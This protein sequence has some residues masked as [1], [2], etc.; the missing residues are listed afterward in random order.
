M[1]WGDVMN[2]ISS[3]EMPP[4]DQPQPAATQATE[5]VNWLAA[6]IKEGEAA[7]L[8]KRERVTFQKL[9]RE[10][11]AH[12]VYDMLGIH[13]D[14]ADPSALTE[15]PSWNGFERIGSVLSFSPAH[16]EKH[17]AAAEAVVAEA[18]PLQR[19][20]KKL[21]HWKP[22]DMRPLRYRDSDQ[23]R[24]D[25]IRLDVWPG[26]T[27]KGQ[28]THT[29]PLVV[30]VSG[31]YL[32][33]VKLSGMQ[34]RGGRAPHVEIYSVDLNRMLLEQDVVTAEDQPITVERRVHLTAGTHYVRMTNDAPGPSNLPRA[35]RGHLRPFYTIQ[36][37]RYPWQTKITDDQGQPILPFLIVDW[38]EFEGPLTDS[39][40]SAA[41]QQ[42]T[43]AP[44]DG[45]ERAREVITRFAQRLPPSGGAGGGRWIG[46]HHGP[47]AGQ[48]R[49]TRRGAQEHL[50]GR[51]VLERFSV[52]R[53]RIS[54]REGRTHHRLG[55]RDAI[56]LLLVEFAAGCP[57]ARSG[58]QRHAAEPAVLKAQVERML[59]DPKILHF[60]EAFARQW[61]Q[62]RLVGM[63]P[64]D[65]KLYPDYDDYLQT[66]M[67][68]ESIEYFREVLQ[69]DLTLREFLDS[70]WTMLNSRLAAHYGIPDV[71][72]DRFERVTLR[73]DDH[74]GGLLTQASIWSL[75][76]DGT[77]HRPVH[78]G[79]WI[80]ESIIGRS[81]PP[82]P[83]NVKPIEPT[84]ATAPKATLRMK[85]AAHKERR[86]LRGVPPADRSAGPGLRQLRR[87]RALAHAG[88]GDRWQRRQPAGRRQ[89]RTD[90][91][92]KICRRLRAEAT[93]ADRPRQVQCGTDRK[94]GHVCPPPRP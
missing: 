79:K 15:D 35:G 87:R 34:P 8:A 11:Y 59:H 61:L 20:E 14:A 28:P 75:T 41:Q 38:V 43:L 12:T 82:P 92:P 49:T 72:V 81:P 1:H 5:I 56:V 84:P 53:R 29:D 66:S 48:R 69:S 74:R 39:W 60:T 77:R 3:G 37:G 26:S 2:R 24:I 93:A 30:P 10:E 86:G 17:F 80:L 64:P 23:P 67:Q 27:F 19:P 50:G 6:R 90:G 73:P 47:R 9:T 55:T 4:D 52:H 70:N 40:P 51:A 42:Y 16:I 25:K 83:A 31:D 78:R 68:R 94:A 88:S 33:R 54:R 91:R 44:A 65:R 22:I 89:R 57:P 13:Y 7:R 45:K 36:E 58:R 76:S 63:F 62:L 32:V 21:I 85:L 46:P 18:F 71:S